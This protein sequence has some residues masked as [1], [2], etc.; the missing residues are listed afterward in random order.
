MLVLYQLSYLFFFSYKSLQVRD[1]D[2]I[3]TRNSLRAAKEST[4]MENRAITEMP[5][6]EKN[7]HFVILCFM[8]RCSVFPIIKFVYA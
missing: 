6:K 2:M 4:T 1:L 3:L 5:C 7:S 8:S